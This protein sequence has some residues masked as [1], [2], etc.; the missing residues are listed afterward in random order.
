MNS[1]SDRD[2]SEFNMAVSYLNRLNNLF[3]LCN[4]AGLNYNGHAWFQ[5]LIVLFREL[6]TEMKDAEIQKKL[7]EINE[8]NIMLSRVSKD[9]R[10]TGKM[11]IPADVFNKLNM[12]ELSLRKVMKESGLQN[13]MKDDPRFALGN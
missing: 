12:F 5:T 10:R 13:K 9:N 3:Y 2:Q 1:N 6:S 8:I 11:Q 7:G 4:N